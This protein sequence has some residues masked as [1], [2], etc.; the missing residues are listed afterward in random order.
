MAWK[1]DK[2]GGPKWSGTDIVYNTASE[3]RWFFLLPG[4]AGLILYIATKGHGSGAVDRALNSVFTVLVLFPSL[5]S[6][7]Y[8]VTLFPQWSRRPWTLTARAGDLWYH[9]EYSWW[10]PLD[11]ITS[12]EVGRTVDWI[13]SR[14]SGLGHAPVSE[15]EWQV[16]LFMADGSRRVIHSVNARRESAARLAA[17]IKSWIDGQRAALAEAVPVAHDTAREGFAL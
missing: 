1:I 4:I 16:F 10:A 11:V 17:S 8:G 9:G 13:P 2:S 5:G 14:R 3:P 6:I 15:F 7:A 12:V